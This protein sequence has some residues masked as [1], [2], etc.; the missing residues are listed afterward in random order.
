MPN[1][2]LSDKQEMAWDLLDDP[3]ITELDYGGA[4][5]GGKTLLFCLW[6]VTQCR[7]YDGIRVGIGRKELKRLKE[8]TLVSLLREAHPILNVKQQDYVYQDQK[9]LV[10]YLNGSEI[11]LVD[12]QRQPSAP[13]RDWET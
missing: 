12:L 1:L 4:A 8:T 2:I 7:Q 13:D 3:Q 5:G 11:V 6:A 10:T 9:G